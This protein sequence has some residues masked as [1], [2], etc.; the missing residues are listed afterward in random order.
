MTSRVATRPTQTPRP[1]TSRAGVKDPLVRTADFLVA[2]D[3]SRGEPEVRRPGVPRP[4]KVRCGC[5]GADAHRSPD[6]TARGR[7]ERS[8]PRIRVL[9]AAEPGTRRRHASRTSP[10]KAPR[11]KRRRLRSPLARPGSTSG[12][13]FPSPLPSFAVGAAAPCCATAAIDVAV[14]VAAVVGPL[15]TPNCH[16]AAPVLLLPAHCSSSLLLLYF[17]SSPCSCSQITGVN[18]HGAAAEVL[19]LTD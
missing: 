5:R 1:R 17:C 6:H 19:V 3:S 14:L 4:A 16:A 18:T 7:K 11:K 12:W 10:P 15:L 2:L 8:R 13:V 9:G